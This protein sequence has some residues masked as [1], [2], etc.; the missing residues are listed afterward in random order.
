M[1]RMI[2][3][4]GAAKLG[5][6]LLI[7]TSSVCAGAEPVPGGMFAI[8][9][10]TGADPVALLDPSTPPPAVGAGPHLNYVAT[11]PGWVYS[12]NSAF[13]LTGSDRPW[14]LRVMAGPMELE[15]GTGELIELVDIE[16]RDAVAP[17]EWRAID[18]MPTWQ[19][20]T[21]NPAM[22]IELQF[23]INV[24]PEHVAGHYISHVTLQWAM[25]P[26][27]VIPAASGT[28]PLELHLDVPQMMSVEMVD[29]ILDFGETDGNESGWIYTDEGL[30][31]I[32]SNVDFSMSISGD[33]LVTRCQDDETLE[34]RIQTAL[35]LRAPLAS[36]A[37]WETWGDLG[38][39]ASG[40]P[41]SPWEFDPDDGSPW[42]GDLMSPAAVIDTPPDGT[43]L[44]GITGAAWRQASGDVAGEYGTTVTITVAAN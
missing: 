20:E 28:I 31:R 17:T 4:A 19:N 41:T 29:Q 15:G 3:H 36:G 39:D 1:A 21:G 18:G 14:F 16:A 11:G 43:S 12:Y 8:Q 25:P 2:C 37:D 24:R 23:R 30:L 34:H 10:E 27:G 42:P 22:Y 38:G 9:G 40:A 13:V 44:I 35:R 6:L 5:L 32:T 33:D 7:I 26:V